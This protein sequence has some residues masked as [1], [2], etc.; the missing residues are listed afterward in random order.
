MKLTN[1]G[2]TLTIDKIPTEPFIWLEVGDS[3]SFKLMHLK[4]TQ[5]AK[6][7]AELI[8]LKEKMK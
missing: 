3:K 6:L 8:K 7:I 1:M 5:V 2:K 4:K